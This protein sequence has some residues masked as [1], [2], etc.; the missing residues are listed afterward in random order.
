MKIKSLIFE[1]WF[2]LGIMDKLKWLDPFTYVD[3]LLEKF[4]PN[5][6]KVVDWSV[7][8]ASAFVFAWILYSLFGIAFGTSTPFVIVLSPSMEPV[9]HR[10]D[11]VVMAGATPETIKAQSTTVDF[12]LGEKAFWDFG[13][14]AYGTDEK[15]KLFA[16]NLFLNEQQV[17][18]ILKDGDTIVYF[19]Q[20]RQEPIIHRA[21]LKITAPDGTFIITKGDSIHNTTIDQDCGRVI[22]GKPERDCITLY[23]ITAKDIQG[24]MLFKIPLLGY[25]KLLIFDDLPQLLFGCPKGRTC[26]FP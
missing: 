23:P 3:I 14:I 13:K 10:G 25:V 6:N 11:I 17:F 20:Y 9:L 2:F 19:S 8:L 26:Y 18:D 15:G 16:K 24:K 12:P 22:N 7:Y 1:E 4:N 21:V 5:H